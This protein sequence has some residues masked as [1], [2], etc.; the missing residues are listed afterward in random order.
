MKNKFAIINFSL[1]IVVLFSMLF[2]SLH[3]YEHIL[4][5]LQ[6]EKCD[7]KHIVAK[8]TQVSHNHKDIEHCF[9]CEFTFS[10]FLSA[11]FSAFEFIKN[12]T[13]FKNIFFFTSEINYF[14]KGISYALR[15]PPIV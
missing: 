8:T 13:S 14:Y 15:G 2:Q 7:K 10:Q 9:T 6:E 4:Q 12:S 5:K 1:M 11:N 3:S